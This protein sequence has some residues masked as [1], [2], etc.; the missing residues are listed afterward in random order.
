MLPITSLY[1]GLLALLFLV[2]S[3]IVISTRIRMRSLLGTEHPDLL[4]TTRA[5]GNFAEY[6]P[7]GLILLGLLEMQQASPTLLHVLG[8][9]LFAGRLLHA[10][11]ILRHKSVAAGSSVTFYFRP[12]G[13]LLTLGSL[14]VAAVSLLVR[15]S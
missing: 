1:A 6:V 3:G 13:M 8:A 15:L 2:L 9:A 10:I 4:R 12:L 5:H 7:L 11:A 14:L